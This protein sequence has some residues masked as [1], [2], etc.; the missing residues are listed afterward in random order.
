MR[1]LCPGSFDPIT[2][3]HMDV[4]RRAVELF[5]DV[6]V[7]VGNNGQKKYMFDLE[8]RVELARQALVAL[9]SVQIE[10]IE[11]L[12]ADYCDSRDIRV[13]VKGLRFG[14]DFDFELQMAHM[15]NSLSG[16]ETVLLPAAV[17]HVTISST[18]LREVLRYGGDV[19]QYVPPVVIET[20]NSKFSQP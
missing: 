4:I 13:V 15:N 10:P 7:G 8:E 2:F 19:S 16:L 5:G 14:S 18:V 9:P 1:V 3:G 20:F 11:G 17:E 6:L 12:L